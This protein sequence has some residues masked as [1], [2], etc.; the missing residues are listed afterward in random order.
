MLGLEDGQEIGFE[1]LDVLLDGGFGRC[2]LLGVDHRLVI[3]EAADDLQLS[4]GCLP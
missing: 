1:F 4:K 3:V 2:S